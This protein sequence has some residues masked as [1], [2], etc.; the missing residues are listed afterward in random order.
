[1]ADTGLRAAEAAWERAVATTMAETLRREAGGPGA[2]ALSDD[3]VDVV[4]RWNVASKS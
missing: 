3:A 2:S 4:E 1:M